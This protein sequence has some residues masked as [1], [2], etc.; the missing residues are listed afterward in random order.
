M[1]ICGNCGATNSESEG[2]FCRKCGA[3]LPA[4]TTK[5]LRIKVS[6][7]AP[8]PP[9]QVTNPTHSS[10]VQNK[11]REKKQVKPTSSA[12]TEVRFFAP[13]QKKE[14]RPT[15]MVLEEIPSEDFVPV[16]SKED[17]EA[18]TDDNSPPKPRKEELKIIP[19][20]PFPEQESEKGSTPFLQEITP[21]PFQGSRIAAKNVY[22]PPRSEPSKKPQD[23]ELTAIPKEKERSKPKI[24]PIPMQKEI[25]TSQSKPE[26]K[27]KKLIEKKPSQKQEDGQFV[28]KQKRLQEDMT[29]VL[30]VLSK[31]FKLMVKEEIPKVVT[32]HTTN[33]KIAVEKLTPTS[34]SEII[35]QLPTIDT[36]IEASA[37]IRTDGTILA[38]AISDRIS[39]SLFATIGQNLSMIGND[40]V[41]GL[42]AGILQSISVRGTE[43][44]LDLAPI[45]RE[46]R[47][48]KDMFL[49]VFSLP[50]VKGGM[51]NLATSLVKKQIKEY[52]GIEK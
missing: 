5:N 10:E 50:K 8:N 51:I 43:G 48:I 37:I 3:L 24:T 36:N 29:D 39:D 19:N 25:P 41:E 42:S 21:L 32:N 13:L 44:I 16:Q 52:L 38:S 35:K 27:N 46:A 30:S 40:I 23:R 20:D 49:V 2:R 28:L 31:S 12:M 7:S 34:M 9:Q 1:K 33:N 6:S 4:S 11:P 22:G 14:A 45:D 47:S 18:E 17:T 26:P 15:N